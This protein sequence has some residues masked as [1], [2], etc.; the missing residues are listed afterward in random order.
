MQILII[1]RTLKEIRLSLQAG[2][3]LMVTTVIRDGDLVL[4]LVH[5]HG[6]RLASTCHTMMVMVQNIIQYHSS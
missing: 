1:Q 2:I 3:D 5:S 6:S 4:F